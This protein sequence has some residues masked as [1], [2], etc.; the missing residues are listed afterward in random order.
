MRAVEQWDPGE[1][2]SSTTMML[3]TS[4]EGNPLHYFALVAQ[5]TAEIPNDFLKRLEIE[6]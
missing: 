6:A 4:M 1:K 2:I 5:K 3:A